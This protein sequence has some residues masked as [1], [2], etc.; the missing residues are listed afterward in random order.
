[1]MHGDIFTYSHCDTCYTLI[2]NVI[3]DNNTPPTYN[4]RPAPTLTKKFVLFGERLTAHKPLRCALEGYHG[5]SI[6]QMNRNGGVELNSYLL[7]STNKASIFF[8]IFVPLSDTCLFQKV[9]AV[10]R[11]NSHKILQRIDDK[12][13]S[14]GKESTRERNFT[15]SGR[16]S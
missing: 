11:Q 16:M 3:N 14:F 15:G 6:L 2:V 4:R 1:M 7:T 5:T 12:M 13:P 9:D 8:S 10:F